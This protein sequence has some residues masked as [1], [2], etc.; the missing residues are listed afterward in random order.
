MY[1]Y[2]IGGGVMRQNNSSTPHCEFLKESNKAQMYTIYVCSSS[3][4]LMIYVEAHL[5]GAA[6]VKIE[7]LK[8]ESYYSYVK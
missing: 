8:D 4:M 5:S 7:V 6:T 3:I 1:I 2:Y